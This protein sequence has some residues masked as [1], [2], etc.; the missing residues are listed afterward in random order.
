MSLLTQLSLIA[1]WIYA[2]VYDAANSNIAWL[3]FDVMTPLGPF[4][5]IYLLLFA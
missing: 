4:R 5:A 1:L 3:I 2:V